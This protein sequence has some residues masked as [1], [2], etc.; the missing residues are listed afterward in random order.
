MTKE[1]ETILETSNVKLWYGNKEALHGIDLNF[2]EKGITALIGPSG[3]G[4][5]TYLRA[6]NRM[7]DLEDNVTV[8]GSFNFKGQDIYA[9]TTDTVDLRKKIGMVF[10][11]PNP[12]PFSIYDNV[13]FGLRLAGVKDKETLDRAVEESLKAA[14]IWEEVK[15]NL[16]KSALGLSGG[17]Q[18]RV[19]IARV[20]AT[21]PDLL[22][23]DEPTSALDP[24]SAHN[25]EDTLLELRDQYAM[26]IVTHSLSQASRISDRTAF[27]M[28][29]NLVEVG[30]TRKIFINPEKQETADYISGRFG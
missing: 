14:S 2:P 9:P 11:Q 24:V 28:N 8:T 18:Q 17:Q 3:S 21:Q 26:I 23:L 10:Q 4:K 22:L 16:N 12:F 27:F 29:G 13:A 19:S 25:I 20:L 5:S 6:L 15:D 1:N 30:D 7:H